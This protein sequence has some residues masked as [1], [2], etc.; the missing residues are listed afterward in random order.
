MQLKARIKRI[1]SRVKINDSPFCACESYKGKVYPAC[2]IVLETNGVQT[3]ENPVA[4]F[5]ERCRKPIE[6]QQI[7][8]CFV[9]SRE[10]VQI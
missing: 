10:Q 3:I 8:V 5:C 7:I 1:E 2:E 9:K 6:K 4:D